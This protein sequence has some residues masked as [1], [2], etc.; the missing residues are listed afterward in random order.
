MGIRYVIFRILYIIKTKIGWK[1]ISFPTNPVLKKHISLD[2]WKKNLPPFFF[3][4]K[5]IKGVEKKPTE[6]LKNNFENITKGI[7]LFFNKSKID[8]GLD[9]DWIT[10]PITK[11]KYDVN[12]HW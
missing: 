8:L 5:E 10:N 6:E 7:Y 2:N 3:N 9:N 11:Y 4:G 1:K 12:K